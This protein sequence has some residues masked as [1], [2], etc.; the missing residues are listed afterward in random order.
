MSSTAPRPV[1]SGEPYPVRDVQGRVPRQL[2]DFTGET[3]FVVDVDDEGYR[4]CGPGVQTD[5]YVR[6]YEKSDEGAGKDVRVW[7][8]QPGSADAPFTATPGGVPGLS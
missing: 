4:V 8:V 6:V 5:E 7:L 2:G 3:T 1:I